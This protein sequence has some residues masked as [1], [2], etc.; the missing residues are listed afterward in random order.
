MAEAG[1][2]QVGDLLAA[3]EQQ[4][5]VG[6][7]TPSQASSSSSLIAGKTQG[8][9]AVRRNAAAKLQT[10]CSPPGRP[11]PQGA[12][13]AAELEQQLY[14]AYGGVNDKYR[15]QLR[16]LLI[17]LPNVLEDVLAGA[18]PAQ[19]LAT[20]SA[21]DLQSKELL[22]QRARILREKLEEKRERGDD[23]GICAKCGRLRSWVEVKGW[24][25]R[26][27]KVIWE[28]DYHQDYC[29]CTEEETAVTAARP[30]KSNLDPGPPL[31]IIA[32]STNG[33]PNPDGTEPALKRP[34]LGS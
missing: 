15:A 11:S 8:D 14:T 33:A 25:L 4:E 23:E 10:K 19:Q 26:D 29:R 2:D 18:I 6:L 30:P 28:Q 31:A 9:A 13:I 12:A 34:K 27:E 16:M 24:Q 3:L 5:A 7:Q 20:C 17:N 22:R 1:G 32:N 21:K